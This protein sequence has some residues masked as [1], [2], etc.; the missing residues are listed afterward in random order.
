MANIRFTVPNELYHRWCNILLYYNTGN[1]Q[2]LERYLEWIE[3][4]N[5]PHGY[6]KVATEAVWMKVKEELSE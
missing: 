6:E 1:R 4:G 3:A 5:V 2:M